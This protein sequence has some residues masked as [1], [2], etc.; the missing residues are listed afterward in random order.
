MTLGLVWCGG[1]ATSRL[2]SLQQRLPNSDAKLVI[3]HFPTA[4]AGASGIC[5]KDIDW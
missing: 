4:A 1:S 3:S 2:P 5:R